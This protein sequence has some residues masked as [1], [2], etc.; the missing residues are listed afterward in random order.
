MSHHWL[1]AWDVY[2]ILANYLR[3]RLQKPA[4]CQTLKNKPSHGNNTRLDTD[5]LLLRD[6]D[7]IVWPIFTGQE[8]C[9]GLSATTH[10]AMRWPCKH[11]LMSFATYSQHSEH[12]PQ[13][14]VLLNLCLGFN[15]LCLDLLR[16]VPWEEEGKILAHSRLLDHSRHLT[17][18][19]LP[20]ELC[21]QWAEVWFGVG[22]NAA[23]RSI[24][25]LQTN[26]TLKVLLYTWRW[27]LWCPLQL[28]RIKRPVKCELACVQQME[29]RTDV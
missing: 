1:I 4:S 26:K 19:V 14:L 25:K 7:V 24:D 12:H 15:I 22:S 23:I 3:E 29:Q 2:I 16:Q 18:S 21:R 10:D 20:L 11:S 8:L 17:H 13:H 5:L 27:G 28:I 9:P 6:S